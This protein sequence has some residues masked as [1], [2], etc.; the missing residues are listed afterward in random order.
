M[1]GVG[2]C[3]GEAA[4]ASA[5]WMRTSHFVLFPPLLSSM[6]NIDKI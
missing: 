2:I 4:G 6:Y 1:V 3:Q 5:S